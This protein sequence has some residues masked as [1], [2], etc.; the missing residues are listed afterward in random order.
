LLTLD[1]TKHC[2]CVEK[3][4]AAADYVIQTGFRNAVDGNVNIVKG[5]V[6]FVSKTP[7]IIIEMDLNRKGWGHY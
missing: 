3:A 4:I 2:I 1:R 5:I 6:A 7:L